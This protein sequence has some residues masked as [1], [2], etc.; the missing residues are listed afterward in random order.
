[1]QHDK[2]GDQRS[3]KDGF[4]KTNLLLICL[5]FVVTSSDVELDYVL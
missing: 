3:D 5:F 1:M 2:T 4:G